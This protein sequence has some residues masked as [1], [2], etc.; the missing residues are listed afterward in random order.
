MTA[1]ISPRLTQATEVTVARASGADVWD[2]QGRQ[3]LDFTSGIAVT[4]T[5]HAH[6]RVVEAIRE[7]AG[8]IIHAQY[9]TIMNPGLIEF[10]ERLGEYMPQG[11]D[12]V[13]Y[14]SAGT[15][16][17]EAAIRLVRHATGR[18]NLVVFEGGFHG[19]TAGALSLTTSKTAYRA[20]LQ[21]LM[22]GVFVTPF[23][24]AF[25][26]GMTEKEATEF[27][28][29]RL[30]ELFATQTA[31]EE[32]AAVFIEPILGEGGYVPAPIGFLEGLAEVAAQHDILLVIDE[33]QSGYGRTGRFWAH[34][35]DQVAP[36]VLLTAKGIASGM[37]LSAMWASEDLMAKARPG[38]QGGTYGGNPVSVAAAIATLEVIEAEGLVE[39]A[40][41]MGTHL[42]TRLAEVA[43][44]G[45]TVGEV[46]GR[47]LMVA[48]EFITPDGQPDPERAASVRREMENSGVL[49]LTAGPHGN[50]VRWAPPL[51]V[52]EEQIDRAVDMFEKGI[53]K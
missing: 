10:T 42:L 13:F 40:A 36:D 30:R 27:A 32:T 43:G 12:S 39:R 19:R 38:S 45:E 17:V 1:R 3:Y 47:G 9:T 25:R 33:I 14:A 35:H 51:I 7:Q 2:T 6:P 50:V 46:R 16:V 44:G 15:E 29:S 18:T 34:Q 24:Y 37:P 28:L 11:L 20:G 49:L 26:L 41:T 23:P 53:T 31:P 22:S 48:T 8:R 52:T 5:G 21:P 4:S